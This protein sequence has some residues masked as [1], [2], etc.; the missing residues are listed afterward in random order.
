MIMS[1]LLLSISACGTNT[2][3]RCTSRNIEIC[4]LQRRVVHIEDR[5]QIARQKSV[6]VT[7][8]DQ[9]LYD[10]LRRRNS[11]VTYPERP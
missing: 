1:V 3:Y 6:P 10:E 5:L 9:E 4:D 7:M 2:P 8:T 11:V